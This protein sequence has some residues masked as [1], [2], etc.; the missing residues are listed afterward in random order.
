[1]QK[2]IFVRWFGRRPRLLPFRKAG[3]RRVAVGR[4]NFLFV[5]SKEAG[6]D[7]AVIYT[8][9]AS[10]EKHGINPVAYLSDVLVRV[11][12]HPASRIE[13]LLPHRY[14][15]PERPVS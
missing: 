3:L 10:C 8:L 2:N 12:K 11:Q 1:M 4:S 14:R 15:P 5:G 6:E 7:L 13:E 9:V